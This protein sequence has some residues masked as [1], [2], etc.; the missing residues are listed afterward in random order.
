MI[1]V[2]Q[3]WAERWS[4]TLGEPYEQ[5]VVAFTTRATTS[6]G[7]PA[8]L[9][10]LEPHR[11]AEHEADALELWNGNGAVKLLR[12][13][14]D[15]Y[16]LLLERCE[17][18]VPLSTL[19][20]DAA[21]DVMITLLPRLWVSAGEPFHTLTD[22]AAWW[23]SYLPDEWHGE[24]RL[25]DAALDAI[26]A[27]SLTQGEQVLLHQDLH[28]DNV[29]AAG[30][31][32]WLVIDPKPL[33]GEREF[34]VAPIARS[35]ELGYSK[36]GMLYRFDRVTAEL[37]LDRERALGW[38]VAQ[39]VAWTGGRRAAQHVQTVEWLLEAA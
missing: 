13:S 33:I 22:E 29:I 2:A 27:L 12:R 1:D 4:L 9:K 5:G 19:E 17:P 31:E 34:Q 30:R 28:F 11:E 35:L 7:T 15:G 18:G 10:V 8:V 38:T 16:V 21:L 3:E 24:R 39:T 25:L 36:R 26:N 14:A 20:P 37:G 23:A 32:P 6:D